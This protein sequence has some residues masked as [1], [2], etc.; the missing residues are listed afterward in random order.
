MPTYDITLDQWVIPYDTNIHLETMDA[1]SLDRISKRIADRLTDDDPLGL[2][3]P[4]L[5]AD[6]LDAEIKRLA[7]ERKQNEQ[8]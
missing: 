3:D 6:E 8:R 5:F 4:F 1:K 7:N 2:I